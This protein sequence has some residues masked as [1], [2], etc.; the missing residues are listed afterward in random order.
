MVAF[1]RLQMK[2]AYIVDTDV[3]QMPSRMK[4]VTLQR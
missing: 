1:P 3:Q 4:P 2:E